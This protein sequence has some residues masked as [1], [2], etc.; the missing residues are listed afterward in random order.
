MTP[1]I[2]GKITKMNKILSV[3]IIFI[4]LS[5]SNIFAQEEIDI[6][7]LDN[8][9]EPDD[10]AIYK[11][12]FNT[13]TECKSKINIEEVGEFIISDTLTTFHKKEFNFSNVKFS[14]KELKLSIFLELEDGTVITNDE[15]TISVPIVFIPPKEALEQSY[16]L[17]TI[18]G[19]FL[20]LTPTPGVQFINDKTKL[21][22]NKELSLIVFAPQSALRDIPYGYFSGEYNY[23]YSADINHLFRLNYKHNVLLLGKTSYISLGIGGFSNF[24]GINGLST[25]LSI[26]PFKI[27][28]SF[29]L[30]IKYRYDNNLDKNKYESHNIQLGFFTNL[31]SLNFNF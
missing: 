26:T 9:F 11:I 7:L 10:N 2:M 12:A 18:L 3:L 17:K 23:I 15:N 28:S 22:I 1:Y 5:V 31:F 13:S 6:F 8:F 14:K 20:W 4:F 24:K 30:Y 27:T 19:F 16:T 21:T 29:D 25:E